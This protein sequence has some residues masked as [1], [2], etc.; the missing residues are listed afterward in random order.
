MF[1]YI[2]PY[3][4]EMLVREYEEYKAVYCALCREMG[5]EYGVFSRLTLSYDCTFY[6]VLLLSL[7]QEHLCFEAKRCVANPLKKCQYC[8]TGREEL[9][10]AAAL[11]VI[12]TYQK[13]I[14]DKA[15][16]G[17][18]G[19]VRS[20]LLLIPA[21]GWRKKARKKYPE[22]DAW[23]EQYMREQRQA[24]EAP[25]LFD[26][27]AEP[28]A[29]L[30]AQLCS[31]GFNGTEKR[32]LQ[33]MGYHLGRWVYLIDAADDIGRDL[34]TGNFNPYIQQL[35]LTETDY[36]KN[37]RDVHVKCN[38]MLNFSLAEAVSAMQLLSFASMGA[39]VENIVAKGLP[40]M[41]R[42][43]LFTEG[44]KVKANVRSL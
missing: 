39:I 18:W 44:K 35:N 6:A 30:L 25:F 36:E 33:E 4:A 20:S 31:D 11:S 34:E 22:I 21:S 5:K 29:H 41:Q 7:G 17:F 8:I 10:K 19:S 38:E 12:L 14:D 42:Q 3:K 37:K 24:E 1:G 2:R 40:Q 27:C 26:R 13:L 16:S 43:I 23:A 32:I 28:T 15:D 9:K